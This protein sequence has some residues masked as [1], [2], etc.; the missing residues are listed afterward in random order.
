MLGS[1]Q[2]SDAMPVLLECAKDVRFFPYV[3]EAQSGSSLIIKCADVFARLKDK[4]AIPWLL[5]RLEEG[6]PAE[7]AMVFVTAETENRMRHV[8]WAWPKFAILI[9]MP[10]M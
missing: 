6:Y 2:S 5:A 9:C 3:S 4:R 8:I 7:A 10:R 1:E